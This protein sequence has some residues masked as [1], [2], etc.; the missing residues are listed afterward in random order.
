MATAPDSGILRPPGPPPLGAILVQRG[1]LTEEQLNAALAESKR[2]GEPTGEVIV[3]FGFASEATIAQALATQHGGPLKTEYGYAVGFGG[4]APTGPVSLPPVS[5]APTQDEQTVASA[6]APASAVR[7]APPAEPAAVPAP[8]ARAASPPAAEAP[9]APAPVAQQPDPV[10]QWQQ[11]AQQLAAQR[12]AAL[13]ANEAIKSRLAELDAALASRNGELTAAAARLTELET[14]RTTETDHALE[15]AA[16][17]EEAASFR[18]EKEVLERARAEAEARNAELE[19]ELA[20]LQASATADDGHLAAATARLAELESAAAHNAETEAD[21]AKAREDAAR[22]QMEKAALEAA[23]ES[24]ASHTADLE[25]RLKT[26]EAAATH[27]EQL[28]R[29]L[30]DAMAQITQ[31]EAERED[32]LKVAKVLGEERRHHDHAEDPAHLLFVPGREGYRLIEQD[33]P[34]PAPGATLE[35]ENDEGTA[36]KLTVTKVGPSPLPG[37][38]LACAYLVAA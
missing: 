15:L 33:G 38:R 19:R 31:L 14:A 3:R 37:T 18:T 32:V 17:R 25:E 27:A 24:T 4:A 29:K 20:E 6:P 28:E 16:A 22:I 12:D 13:R 11:Y 1:L 2:T 7:A 34:P 35:L 8:P 36:R 30:E 21:L 9:A 26:L 23:R 5:P 10:T